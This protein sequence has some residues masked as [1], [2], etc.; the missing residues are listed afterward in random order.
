MPASS[1]RDVA[2][3]SAALWSLT[4]IPAIP[5]LAAPDL[6]AEVRG[7][8]GFTLAPTPGTTSQVV[9]IA[10]TNA[11][12]VVAI[13]L[14]AWAT[15]RLQCLRVPCDA[16]VAFITVANA[17]L[18]GLALGA[19]G[20]AALP[21]LVHLPLEWTALSVVLGLYGHGRTRHLTA[22]SAVWHAGLAL[23]LVALGAGVE[24]YV[25]PQR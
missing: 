16:V 23:T 25:T 1:C 10:A 18:V 4:L 20:T 21:W 24:T 7:A 6:A 14:A 15:I 11:R 12:V 2:A 17:T 19:H 13:A 5:L 22:A 3:A 8:L 9:D